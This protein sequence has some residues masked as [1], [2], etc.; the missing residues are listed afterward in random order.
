M[1]IAESVFVLC[2]IDIHVS[3]TDAKESEDS[4]LG[5]NT[6]SS[7]LLIYYVKE[8]DFVQISV[9]VLYI[10]LKKHNSEQVSTLAF[11]FETEVELRIFPHTSHIS[12]A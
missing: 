2:S 11:Q 5:I 10:F 8:V 6:H 3:Y 7:G 4:S 9:F 12:Q 1:D